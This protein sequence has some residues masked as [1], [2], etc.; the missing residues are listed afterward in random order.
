[1]RHPSH[2]HNDIGTFIKP[3]SSIHSQSISRLCINI[4][5]LSRGHILAAK[6]VHRNVLA[7]LLLPDDLLVQYGCRAP[8]EDVALLLLATLVR[9]NEASLE[10]RLLPSPDR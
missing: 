6:V 2:P 7:N 5:L 9:L 8:R 4:H 1:M 3:L 10:R